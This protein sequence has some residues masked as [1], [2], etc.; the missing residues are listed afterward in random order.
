MADLDINE[1]GQESPDQPVG[2]RT[3][4]ATRRQ[5]GRKDPDEYDIDQWIRQSDLADW[6]QRLERGADAALHKV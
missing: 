1:S 6:L 2:N 4:F 5:K 3:D